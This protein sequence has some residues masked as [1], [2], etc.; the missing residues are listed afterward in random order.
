MKSSGKRRRE[1]EANRKQV[2]TTAVNQ[3]RLKVFKHNRKR[4]ITKK[5]GETGLKQQEKRTESKN[6]QCVFRNQT[7]K[8]SLAVLLSRSGPW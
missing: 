6:N 2:A 4:C 8:Q 7:K 3:G 5:K 1:R